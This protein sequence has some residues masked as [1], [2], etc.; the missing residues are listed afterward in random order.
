MP[1]TTG[2]PAADTVA[3]A[4]ALSPM[5]AMEDGLGP[6]KANP[7]VQAGLGK[8]R[9]LCQEAITGWMASAPL[10]S[11]NLDDLIAAQVRIRA[12]GPG[13]ADRLHRHSARAA[14]GGRLRNKRHG[15]H[16]QLAAGADDAHGDLAAVG[17]QTL[18]NIAHLILDRQGFETLQVYLNDHNGMLPCFLGGLVSR[19]LDSISSA[20]IRRGRVS[21][22]SITSSM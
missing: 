19:L 20:L 16:A 12:M 8:I 13:R 15:L 4:T 2:T 14:P 3:R 7:G 9:A 11:G 1:G 5:A 18:L 17:D 10:R 6:M 21:C 22:G